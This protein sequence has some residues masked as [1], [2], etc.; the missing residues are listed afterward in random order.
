MQAEHLRNDFERVLWCEEIGTYAL[1]LD[2][3]R[4]A[5]LVATLKARANVRF[6]TLRPISSPASTSKR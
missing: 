2:R 6:A 1:A 5:Y 4:C 3:D